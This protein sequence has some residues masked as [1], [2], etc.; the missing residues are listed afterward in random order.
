MANQSCILDIDTQE[1]TEWGFRQSDLYKRSSSQYS[2][3]SILSGAI[4]DCGVST[5]GLT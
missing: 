3:V 1:R 5:A 2:S 4:I